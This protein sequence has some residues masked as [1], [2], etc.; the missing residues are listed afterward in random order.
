MRSR[1]ILTFADSGVLRFTTFRAYTLDDLG[2]L[3]SRAHSYNPIIISICPH[4]LLIAYSVHWWYISKSVCTIWWIW[5]AEIPDGS[6]SFRARIINS[7]KTHSIR[8]LFRVIHFF[9]YIYI[10]PTLYGSLVN[11][12]ARIWWNKSGIIKSSSLH[13]PQSLKLFLI[14]TYIRECVFPFDV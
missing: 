7:C 1:I 9:L 8:M 13:A 14:R 4:K 11:V 12:I 2:L 10:S 3:H 5:C 6:S